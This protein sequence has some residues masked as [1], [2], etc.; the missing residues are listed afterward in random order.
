MPEIDENINKY[1]KDSDI[2]EIDEE[3][4]N[5]Y[6]FSYSDKTKIIFNSIEKISKNNFEIEYSFNIFK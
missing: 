6:L 5:I 2:N 3:Q 4:N 1:D